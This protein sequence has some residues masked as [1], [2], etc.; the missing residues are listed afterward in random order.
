[1]NFLQMAGETVMVT[2]ASS[3]AIL[4]PRPAANTTMP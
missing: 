3:N 2:G 1:M 4:T